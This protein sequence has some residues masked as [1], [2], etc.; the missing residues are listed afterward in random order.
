M[1]ALSGILFLGET[2]NGVQCLALLAIISASAG[3]TLTMKPKT[4]AL[5]PVDINP[6][7]KT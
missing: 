6:H 3:S 7:D 1:A 5:K 2:L 4:N